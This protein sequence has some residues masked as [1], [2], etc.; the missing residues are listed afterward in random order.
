LACTC[1]RFRDDLR[2]APVSLAFEP[3]SGFIAFDLRISAMN[4]WLVG[5]VW[6][7]QRRCVS[8]TTPHNNPAI[9]TVLGRQPPLVH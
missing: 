4:V 1:W 7:R 8:P 9:A 3:S 5:G 2:V 6:F